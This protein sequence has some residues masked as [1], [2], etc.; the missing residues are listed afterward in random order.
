MSN[1]LKVLAAIVALVAVLALAIPAAAQDN[2]TPSITVSGSGEA[3]GAP[4]IAYVDIGVDII[5]ENVGAAYSEAGEVIN[6]VLDA[7]TGLGIER[8]DIQTTGLNIWWEEPPQ[9]DG[10]LGKRRYHVNPVLR[11]T[12]RD[13][14]QIEAVINTS[15]ENGANNVFG[16]SFGIEDQDALI[17]EAR[18]AALE[19]ARSRAEHLA[20]LNGV[21]LGEVLYIAEATAGGFPPSPFGGKGGYM[22]EAALVGPS[23]EP[24][25]LKVSVSVSITYAIAR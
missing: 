11:I 13:V 6:R 10:S 4:D 7:L 2:A 12:V 22:A 20:E 14:S 9:P 17:R 21:T 18:A 5:N 15:V 1:Y 8:K 19:D 24:G 16:L 3:A 25:Q 23:V